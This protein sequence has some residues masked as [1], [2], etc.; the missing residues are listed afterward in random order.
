MLKGADDRMFRAGLK[1]GAAWLL[2][3]PEGK[4][5]EGELGAQGVCGHDD[6]ELKTAGRYEN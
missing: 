6:E 2:E 4:E 5:L 1:N 3:N